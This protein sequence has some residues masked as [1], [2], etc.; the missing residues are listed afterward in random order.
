MSDPESTPPKFQYSLWSLLVLATVVAI[1]CSMVVSAGWIVPMLIVVGTSVC[2]I[3]FGPL[4]RLKHPTE[5]YIFV[6]SGFVVRL[7]GL[8][9]VAFAV[10]LW[11]AAVGH[12]R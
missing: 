7:I 3:G 11:F 6:L 9:I 4:S 12:R 10:V 1:V 8:V 5:G 2:A